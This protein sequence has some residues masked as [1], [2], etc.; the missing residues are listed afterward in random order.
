MEVADGAQAAVTHMGDAQLIHR[1]GDD[2]DLA[3][4]R[5]AFDHHLRLDNVETASLQIIAELVNPMIPLATG[6]FHFHQA[7]ERG[8]AVEVVTLQRFFK[9]I[10]VH[11][12][13]FFGRGGGA[14]GAGQKSV[15]F[16]SQ[17]PE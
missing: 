9:P 8:Q 13:V 17:D 10:N 3:Q 5:G 1:F 6:Q 15:E 12:L 11:P 16:S 7:V 2:G 14:G 4:T